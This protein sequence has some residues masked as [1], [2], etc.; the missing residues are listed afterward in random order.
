[1]ILQR[2]DST[3]ADFVVKKHCSQTAM[4][5]SGPG[6]ALT[7]RGVMLGPLESD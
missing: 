1:M 3:I 5:Q 7:L 4:A 2:P 6:N